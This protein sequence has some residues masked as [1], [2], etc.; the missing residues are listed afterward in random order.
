[1]IDH[2]HHAGILQP[3]TLLCICK[4]SLVCVCV[5]GELAGLDGEMCAT[6]IVPEACEKQKTQRQHCGA[7]MGNTAG[8]GCLYLSTFH[9]FYTSPINDSLLLPSHHPLV[10]PAASPPPPR[11]SIPNSAYSPVL[12]R[13]FDFFFFFLPSSHSSF[14]RVCRAKCGQ[15]LN[16]FAAAYL[17]KVWR[18]SFLSWTDENM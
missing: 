17:G 7:S 4:Y 12:L 10:C 14:G 16:S 13:S 6:L 11:P 18:C 3:P 5:L 15:V 1:M 9:C 8:G 2:D